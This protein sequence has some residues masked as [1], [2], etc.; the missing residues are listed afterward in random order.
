MWLIDRFI[1]PNTPA[2][3]KPVPSPAVEPAP[4]RV[5][6]RRTPR[7]GRSAMAP[8]QKIGAAGRF[9]RH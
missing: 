9:S 7:L 6:V 2:L 4:R 8:W 5:V 1:R 3:N